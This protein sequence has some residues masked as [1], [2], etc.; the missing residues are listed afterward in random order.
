V[1]GLPVSG[2]PHRDRSGSGPTEEEVAE[3]LRTAQRLGMLGDRAIPE[4]IAHAR[5]FVMALEG[6]QGSVCDLGSGGGV[7]GLVIAMDRPDLRVVLVDRR[8]KRTDFLTRE[9]ARLGFGSRVEVLCEDSN[10][11]TRRRPRFFDAVTARGFGPPAMTLETAEQLLSETGR[12]VISEPP[13][14]DRWPIEL[15]TSLDLGVER[16]GAVSIFSRGRLR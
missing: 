2:P 7:P 10:S 14:Q 3:T 13:N 11:L 8:Q 5:S 16:L 15:L 12:I 9:V 4:V 1:N 6:I